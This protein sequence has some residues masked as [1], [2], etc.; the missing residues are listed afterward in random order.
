MGM[1]ILTAG[2]TK[3]SREHAQDKRSIMHKPIG[4]VCKKIKCNEG[5]FH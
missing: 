2:T 3:V 5:G 4:L 1:G